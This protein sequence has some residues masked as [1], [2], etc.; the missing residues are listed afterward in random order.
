[1]SQRALQPNKIFNRVTE[2][3]ALGVSVYTNEQEVR[4]MLDELPYI[5]KRFGFVVQV[6]LVPGAGY[7]KKTG[8]RSPSHH[9]WWALK[10]FDIL[11]HCVVILS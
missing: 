6:E 1:M 3:Q 11:S 4:K 5:R 2:C 10:D 8:K 7:I 9:T